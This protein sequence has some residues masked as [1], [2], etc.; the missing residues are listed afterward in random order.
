M[1]S[2]ATTSIDS[3]LGVFP[4]LEV[5]GNIIVDQFQSVNRMYAITGGYG[6][7]KWVRLSNTARNTKNIVKSKISRLE[8]IPIR[9]TIAY[10]AKFRFI[11]PEAFWLTKKKVLRNVD[12]TNMVKL[13]EDA[14]IE[15]L[16]LNDKKC[17]MVSLEKSIGT[18]KILFFNYCLVLEGYRN[19]RNLREK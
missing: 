7:K 2:K 4:F 1:P 14:L 8:P 17:R 5:N 10:T 9:D 19:E 18:S 12:L 15:G 11:A 13:L 6:A 3:F 16:G